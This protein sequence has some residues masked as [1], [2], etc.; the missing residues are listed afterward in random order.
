L[1]EFIPGGV[2]V[3]INLIITLAIRT[4]AA[5]IMGQWGGEISEYFHKT[6]MNKAPP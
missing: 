5:G 3:I 1:R 6:A 4:E 2:E